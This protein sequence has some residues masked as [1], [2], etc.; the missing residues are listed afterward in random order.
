MGP[1]LEL[2]PSEGGVPGQRLLPG[3]GDP[4]RGCGGLEVQDD[5]DREGAVCWRVAKKNREE[6]RKVEGVR[7]VRERRE[8]KR[9]DKKTRAFIIIFSLTLSLSFSLS[10]DAQN[11][12]FSKES[13][14]SYKEVGGLGGEKGGT[15]LKNKRKTKNKKESVLKKKRFERLSKKKMKGSRGLSE[16]ALVP[17]TKNEMGAV[18][19]KE[20]NSFPL[21]LF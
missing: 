9:R 6:G 13:I 2:D 7:E 3:R 14:L 16:R 10:T 1:V 17:S 8:E 11:F 12:V 5:E 4:E 18:E 15:I 19:T 20:G 21:G